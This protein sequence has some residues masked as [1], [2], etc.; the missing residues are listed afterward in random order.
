M[1]KVMAVF[2][3]EYLERVRRKSFIIGLILVPLFMSAVI[4]LP[5]WLSRVEAET[6][7][8]GLLLDA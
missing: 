2:I 4:V 8:R 5:L 3:R 7:S 6:A 1:D